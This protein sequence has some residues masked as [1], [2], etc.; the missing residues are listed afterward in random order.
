LARR[1][2]TEEEAR[3][4]HLE[5]VKAY[6]WRRRNGQL[7]QRAGAPALHDPRV[8]VPLEV[9]ADRD[10]RASLLPVSL[11]QALLGDP[12][13]GRSALDRILRR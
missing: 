1:R 12:L 11:T 5:Q 2:F 13:P 7:P 10:A 9:L 3:K 6:Q 8:D 4:R